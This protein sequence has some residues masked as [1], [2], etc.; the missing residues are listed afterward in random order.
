[1]RTK[2]SNVQIISLTD[3]RELHRIADALRDLARPYFYQLSARVN[4]SDRGPMDLEVYDDR[5]GE[6]IDG[7][8]RDTMRAIVHVLDR[9]IYDQLRTEDEYQSGDE[10]VAENIRANAYEFTEEGKRA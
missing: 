4:D 2:P 8:T 10:T 6:T 9:W 7:E 5:T 1:M 3:G